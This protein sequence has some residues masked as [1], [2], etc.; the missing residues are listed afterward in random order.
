[1][2]DYDKWIINDGS[3]KINK[4]IVNWTIPVRKNKLHKI[5]TSMTTN[6][7]AAKIPTPRV[8]YRKYFHIINPV[9]KWENRQPKQYWI[10]YES[11]W[12]RQVWL[13]GKLL[14]ESTH[15]THTS[16]A[17]RIWS[18]VGNSCGFN[19][20]AIVALMRKKWK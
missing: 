11:G 9:Q 1:M 10:S 15:N 20:W 19:R 17:G 5:Y 3:I 2:F 8:S 16:S 7:F 18:L 14:N 6:M 12:W 4:I 13:N